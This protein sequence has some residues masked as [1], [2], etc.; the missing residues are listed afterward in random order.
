MAIWPLDQRQRCFHLFFGNVSA[1][2][3]VPDGEYVLQFVCAGALASPVILIVS[4]EAALILV[5]RFARLMVYGT[6]SAFASV[7]KLA[8]ICPQSAPVTNHNAGQCV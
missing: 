5:D 7:H 6:V 2:D 1:V 3:D 4:S 8:L